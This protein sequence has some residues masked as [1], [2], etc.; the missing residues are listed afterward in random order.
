MLI[1][2]IDRITKSKMTDWYLYTRVSS[3]KQV[4]EG[5]GLDSQLRRCLN[6]AKYNNLNII[7]TYEEKA[8]SGQTLY[9]PELEKLFLDL[10]ENKNDKVVLDD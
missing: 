8:V 5:N 10:N 9:R 1:E 7:I 3:S 2:N 6:Y 4:T